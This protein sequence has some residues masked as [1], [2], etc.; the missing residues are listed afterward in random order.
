LILRVLRRSLWRIEPQA[1]CPT[2]PVNLKPF[3]L[4]VTFALVTKSPRC[5]PSFFFLDVSSG[6]FSS[7]PIGPQ[8]ANGLAAQEEG[9]GSIAIIAQ[10]FLGRLWGF[11]FPVGRSAIARLVTSPGIPVEPFLGKPS[12]PFFGLIVPLH[13]VKFA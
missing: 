1:A 11:F 4:D 8:T 10:L 6:F 3:P 12:T 7:W 9:S 5:C 13:V 2:P